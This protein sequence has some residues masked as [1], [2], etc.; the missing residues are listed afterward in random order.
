MASHGMA[1]DVFWELP[2]ELWRSIEPILMKKGTPRPAGP[3]GTPR[4]G[5]V[6]VVKDPY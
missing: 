5:A 4:E 2:D 1:P 3:R 6:L